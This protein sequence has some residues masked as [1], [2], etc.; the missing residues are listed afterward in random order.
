M[1]PVPAVLVSI[2]LTL[3][4]SHVFA[5]ARLSPCTQSNDTAT[6]TNCSGELRTSPYAKYVGEFMNG[7][8]HGQGTLTTTA[9]AQYVGEWRDGKPNG[10]G[11]LTHSSGPFTGQKYVGGFRDGRYH[12]QGVEYRADGS[13]QRSGIWENGDLVKPQ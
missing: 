10:Q 6:W 3:Q 9:G 13:V 4:A 5:Q 2:F 11:A 7:K 12:G 1:K 8:P